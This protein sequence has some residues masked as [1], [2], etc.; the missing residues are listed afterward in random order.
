M[1]TDRSV[2][3][4]NASSRLTFSCLESI[5]TPLAEIVNIT[6]RT[7]RLAIHAGLKKTRFLVIER[8]RSGG[9]TMRT[10]LDVLTDQSF[11]LFSAALADQLQVVRGQLAAAQAPP[12]ARAD[13]APPPPGAAPASPLSL[14]DEIG[15]LAAL[16]EQGALTAEEFAAMKTKLL[17]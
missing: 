7:E 9:R 2:F 4:I 16:R 15:K 5:E 3:E 10:E 1:L 11:A 17:G 8:R 14:A 6:T 12:P 13:V